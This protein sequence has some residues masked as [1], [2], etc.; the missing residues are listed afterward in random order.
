MKRA[1]PDIEPTEAFLITRVSKSTTDDWKKLRRCLTWIKQSI[2]DV[3]IIGVTSLEDPFTW[4]DAAYEVYEN[5]RR[6]TGGT[7]S[8][9]WRV[10]HSKS[11]KTKV[12][13]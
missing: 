6:H 4:I 10:I 8:M 1:R 2:D 11:S 9:G 5:M 7:M 12:K 13:Y 3:R